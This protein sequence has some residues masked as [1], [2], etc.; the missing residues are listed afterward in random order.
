MSAPETEMTRRAQPRILIVEDEGIVARDILLRLKRLGYRVCGTAATGREAIETALATRPDLVLMDVHLKGDMDGI[1]AARRI[2]GAL[3]VPVVY[4]TAY[5][6]DDTIQRA[7]SADAVGY[8]LKPFEEREL[9]A[10]IEVALQRRDMERRL[11][12]S[13]AWLTTILRSIGDALIA[14]DA[15]GRVVFMNPVAEAL[16]GWT[17]ADARGQDARR[18][19]TAL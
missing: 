2:D 16:T 5:S 13:Q 12:A 15:E 7:A 1:A 6:D 3:G 11:K 18:V 14:S 9:R 10:A 4:L 19:F 8:L 17:E